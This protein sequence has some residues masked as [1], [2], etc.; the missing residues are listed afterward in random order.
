VSCTIALSSSDQEKIDTLLATDKTIVAAFEDYRAT[1][2][3]D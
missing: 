3:D 2:E 1:H